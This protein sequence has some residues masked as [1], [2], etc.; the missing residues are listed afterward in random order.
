MLS[1]V[2]PEY[3]KRATVQVLRAPKDKPVPSGEVREKPIVSILEERVC[4]LCVFFLVVVF[5]SFR[6]M[7]RSLNDDDDDYDDDDTM[8]LS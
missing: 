2:L 1:S 4:F 6:S 5:F 3:R 7:C 8:S